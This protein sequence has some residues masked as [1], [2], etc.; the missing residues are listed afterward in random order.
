MK[1][2]ERVPKGNPDGGQWTVGGAAARIDK[3][4]TDTAEFS[5][6]FD[7]VSQ[8]DGGFTY[9][10]LAGEPVTGFAVSPYPERSFA[11]PVKEFKFLDLVRYAKKNRD[12]LG[13]PGHYIGAWHDPA[14]G[15]VFLDISVVSKSRD[16]AARLALRHDQI[17]YFDLAAGSSVTVNLNATSG[18]TK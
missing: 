17:A 2:Q 7:R 5:K 16:D 11:A 18:G 10:P 4:R 9:S 12:M 8:P 6:M 14:S 1:D 15:K 13:K 3:Q